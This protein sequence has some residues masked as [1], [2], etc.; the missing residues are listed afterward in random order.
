MGR[1]LESKSEAG[2]GSPRRGPGVRAGPLDLGRTDG[3]PEEPMAGEPGDAG[4]GSVDAQRETV[5]GRT[6]GRELSR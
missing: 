5:P 2:T 3:T 1:L 4:D 6:G